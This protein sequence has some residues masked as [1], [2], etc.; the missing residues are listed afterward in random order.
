MPLVGIVGRLFPIK[1]HHLFLEAAA[2]LRASTP[3][4]RFVVVGDGPLRPR[5]EERARQPDLAGRVIF[6]GWRHDLS[7]IYA[8]LDVLVV[9]SINE[10]TPVSAIEAMAAGCAVVATRVGGLP[11]LIDDGRTG[12]LVTP[13]D[14]TALASAIA[15]Q[16]TDQT[17]SERM[18]SAART[19][20]RER[21]M[22]SRLVA[23]LQRL[24][25]DLLTRKGVAV[26]PLP[27]GGEKKVNEVVAL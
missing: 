26:P 5:L 21:F 13:G 25:L 9:S 1:N 17:D 2:R 18:R 6:T 8:D 24:Y 19:D 4:V 10:G 22:A 23:D 15:R 16:L 14:P 20:V 11:D 27:G 3:E 7:K 12:V